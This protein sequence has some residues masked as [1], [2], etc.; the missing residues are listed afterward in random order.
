MALVFEH[1]D[2]I[3]RHQGP[4]ENFTGS[5]YFQ[6][7]AT[8][9]ACRLR[10]ARVTFEKGARTFWHAHSGEQVLYF[11]RGRGRVQ[12]LGSPAVDAVEGD[13]V[14]IPAGI[15]HWHG[16][17]PNEE[18]A[19]QHLAITFGETTWGQPVSE[20]EYREG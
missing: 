18:H 13:V 15:D 2:D 6:L 5:A 1:I 14:R 3:Q 9:E 7:V 16:S 8:N 4:P 10:A 19:M 11:L 17:H 12:E 20:E